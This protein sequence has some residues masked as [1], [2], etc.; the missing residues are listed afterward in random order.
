MGYRISHHVCRHE[1]PCIKV[2][3]AAL[4]LFLGP[5]YHIKVLVPTLFPTPC[6][7]IIIILNPAATLTL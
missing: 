5:T 2:L 6:K 3:S 1:V 4:V 7:I